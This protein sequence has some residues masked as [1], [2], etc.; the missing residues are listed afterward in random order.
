MKMRPLPDLDLAKISP[1]PTDQKRNALEALRL[2]RPPY[3]YNPGRKFQPDILNIEVG[4]LGSVPR[5]SLE[6]II[7]RVSRASKSPEEEV[8]NVLFA[9]ALYRFATENGLVGQKHEFFP[10][11]VGVSEKVQYWTPG[12]VKL[13][14]KPTVLF[15]DPRRSTR[16]TEAGRRFAFSAMHERIRAADADFANVELAIIQFDDTDKQKRV[17]RPYFASGVDLYSFEALDLMVRETYEIW[18]E[19]LAERERE[20]RPARSA[21]G[22]GN[23]F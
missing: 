18:R 20:E 17:A 8:A 21:A 7:E 23:L 6:Q 3:S 22:Q 16:L 1:L 9:S 12:V 14:G 13:S 11:S 19:V 10:L 5:A 4:P 2:K 15:I